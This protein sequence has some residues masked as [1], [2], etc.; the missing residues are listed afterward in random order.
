MS[1]LMPDGR[2]HPASL[3]P[4]IRVLSLMVLAAA[5]PTMS[6]T[7][8]ATVAVLLLS[9]YCVLARASLMRLLHGLQRL[10]WLFLALWVLYLGFTPGE[11][12]LPQLP[13]L[14]REGLLEGSRRALILF[15]LLTAVYLLLAMT[16]VP[17][18]IQ[19]L[20]LGTRPLRPLGFNGDRLALR[21]AL[22]MEGVGHAERELA[23]VRTQRHGALEAAAAMVVALEARADTLVGAVRLPAETRP[24]LWQWLLP[25][26]LAPLLVWTP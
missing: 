14:S 15:D 17:Q 25:L 11:P 8:V 22:A 24:P 23:R 16:S 12:L 13:G 3:H 2:A 6:L 20:R 4:L 9:T 21:L 26:S 1:P 5:L 18:L 19:A 7:A 10:R